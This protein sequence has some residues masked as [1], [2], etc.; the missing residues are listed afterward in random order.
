MLING[1]YKLAVITGKH[2]DNELTTLLHLALTGQFT[3]TNNLADAD[4]FFII[5]ESMVTEAM[6]RYLFTQNKLG[7]GLFIA[8]NP[9]KIDLI[10]NAV[11]YLNIDG[12]IFRNLYNLGLTFDTSLILEPNSINFI[13]NNENSIN[14]QNYPLFIKG[15]AK[16]RNSIWH[17]LILPYAVAMD[18][19]SDWQ[20]LVYSSAN[21]YKQQGFI[22]LS[23]PLKNDTLTPKNGPFPIVSTRK[24]GLGTLIVASSDAIFTDII[25]MTNEA[26]QN[27]IIADLLVW[28]LLNRDDLTLAKTKFTPFT[29][30]KNPFI[31]KNYN[32]TVLL[33]NLACLFI[34]IIFLWRIKWS[35]R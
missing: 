19:S 3:L 14:M 9:V 15:L 29:L 35:K 23:P 17:G 24:N 8:A 31:I 12:A 13:I 30:L 21:S 33:I 16:G 4:A 7:K 11:P 26:N 28:K 10:S 6:A 27:L 18:S 5:D 25:L 20:N 34:F 22:D 1:Q 2:R 32:A